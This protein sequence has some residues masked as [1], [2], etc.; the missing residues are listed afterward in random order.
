MGRKKTR[1]RWC[2]A[3]ACGVKLMKTWRRRRGF[4]TG[5]RSYTTLYTT[6]LSADSTSGANYL[7]FVLDNLVVYNVVCVEQF[8]LIVVG[9]GQRSGHFVCWS[10]GKF[11]KRA[12]K[13]RSSV[14]ALDFSTVVG[15]R[16]VEI[17]EL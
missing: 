5:A 10:Y 14:S 7:F 9:T 8:A 4:E 1:C 16:R 11:L 6:L 3:T 13:L 12:M 15:Y 17:E 2:L